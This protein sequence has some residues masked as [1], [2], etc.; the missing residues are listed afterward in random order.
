VQPRIFTYLRGCNY[1]QLLPSIFPCIELSTHSTFD[2]A[3]RSK[4]AGMPYRFITLLSCALLWSAINGQNCTAPFSLGNDTLIC[5]GEQL[6][7]TPDAFPDNPL[8]VAWRAE[9]SLTVAPDGQSATAQPSVATTYRLDIR[10]LTGPQLVQNG[11]FSQGDTGFSSD[12]TFGNSTGGN[13]PLDGEGQY[14]VTNSP[15]SVHNN[16]ANCGD[17]SSGS[18]N[19]LVVNGADSPVNVW[20]QTISVSP[21]ET[22][23]FGAYVT[24]VVSE[25]P[26]ILQFRINGQLLSSPFTAQA[27]TCLWTEFFALWE[28]GSNSAAEIC[29][30]NQ[31]T[32]DAGNDFAIDDIS[33]R[34]TCL[35]SDSIT[36]T[37]T[38]PPIIGFDLPSAVC[39]NSAPLTLLELLTSDSPTDGTFS[40]DGNPVTGSLDPTQLGAGDFVLSYVAGVAGCTA[41]T[42]TLL[43]IAAAPSAGDF[44]NGL[45]DVID[46]CNFSPQIYRDHFQAGFSGDPGGTFTINGGPA[47]VNINALTGEIDWPG[48]IAEASVYRVSY[49]IPAAGTCAADTNSFTL[50]IFPAPNLELDDVPSIDCVEEQVTVRLSGSPSPGFDYQWLSGPGG[51]LLATGNNLTVVNAGSYQLRAINTTSGCVDS[52]TITVADLRDS[53]FF[54]LLVNQPNC[55]PANSLVNGSLAV[56]FVMGGTPPFMYRLDDGPLLADTVFNGL[57]AGSYQLTVEDAAGCTSSTEASLADPRNFVFQLTPNGSVRLEFG[58]TQP[59][60]VQSDLPATVLDSVRWFPGLNSGSR[61]LADPAES[62]LYFATVTSPEGCVFTDSVRLEPF[63]PNV[64]YAPNAFS[65]NGDGVNDRWIPFAHPG[66]TAVRNLRIFDRWGG[67]VFDLPELAGND[68]NQGW[69][70]SRRGKPVPLGTYSWSL[71]VELFDGSQQ[72]FSGA[73][74]VLR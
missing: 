67:V 69:N 28:S 47:L 7:I 39:S 43:A 35:N 20:C 61:I 30:S 63:L 15:T 21:N 57:A 37:P 50:N 65:P 73:V 38:E 55:G 22:Y 45:T 6:V 18:G 70:G 1:S 66:V 60:S 27:A 41:T 51:N 11:D 71:E 9:S 46:L 10:T 59:L 13:G 25:N 14:R 8:A 32:I 16:Y 49:I 19:M 48:P 31:N 74:T 3:T 56:P 36:V 12:Y 34:R 4:N 44:F 24:S 52:T 64:I 42:T 62:L 17:Q 72:R 2:P 53:L 68:P 5:Q 33:F 23:A 40:L 26:A 58:E 29:I 54:P